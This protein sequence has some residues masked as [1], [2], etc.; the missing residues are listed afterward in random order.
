MSE[1]TN[2][3]D[4]DCE[5]QVVLYKFFFDDFIVLEYQIKNTLTD[6]NLID[7]KMELIFDNQNIKEICS[8]NAD[9]IGSE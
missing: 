2:L 8:I 4:K 6:R 5:Y 7:V 3:S 1:A 9:K